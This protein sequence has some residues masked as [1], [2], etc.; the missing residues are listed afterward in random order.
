LTFFQENLD[1]FRKTLERISKKSE[2]E[3]AVL[4]LNK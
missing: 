4:S 1:F 3:Y 2:S